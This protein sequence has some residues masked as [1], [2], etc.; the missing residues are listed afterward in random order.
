MREKGSVVIIMR[1]GFIH[2][3]PNIYELIRATNMNSLINTSSQNQ[4]LVNHLLGRRLFQKKITGNLVFGI[5]GFTGIEEFS[6]VTVD[7]MTM[8][9]I[10]DAI[11]WTLPDPRKN[12]DTKIGLIVSMSLLTF[13]DVYNAQTQYEFQTKLLDNMFSLIDRFPELQWFYN[14][15]IDLPSTKEGN[16]QKTDEKKSKIIYEDYTVL[17]QKGLTEHELDYH[18]IIVIDCLESNNIV[19]FHLSHGDG[20]HDS[21]S[22]TTLGFSLNEWKIVTKHHSIREQIDIPL[23]LNNLSKEF[24]KYGIEL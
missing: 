10:N 11:Q 8:K 13:L 21:T 4:N 1:V 16:D 23:T 24:V 9:E 12:A 18:S 14:Y 22:I 7:L 19:D 3:T 17:K 20:K 6:H 15:S 5:T 2:F